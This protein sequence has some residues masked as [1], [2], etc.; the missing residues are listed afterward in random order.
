MLFKLVM[1]AWMP[2]EEGEF[3]E[4]FTD[5]YGPDSPCEGLWFVDN[6]FLRNYSYPVSMLYL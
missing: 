4:F 6:V 5:W 2:L 3:V 1:I